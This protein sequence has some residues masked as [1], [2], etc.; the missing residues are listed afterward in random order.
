[1]TIKSKLSKAVVALILAGAPAYMISDQFLQEK[2][3][4]RLKAYQDGGGVWTICLGHTAGVKPGD[5]AT[6]EQCAAW[7]RQDIEPAIKRVEQLTPVALTEPQKAGI[8]SFCFFNLGETKCRRNA[9]GTP[10]KFWSAWMAGDMARACAQIPNWI[11][12]GGRDC[13]IRSNNCYGQVERRAQEA[14]LCRYGLK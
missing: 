4:M 13:R 10:T 14:E 12:D 3:G 7:A 8:A 11:Y 6:P 5:T 1:M 9:N 2:E